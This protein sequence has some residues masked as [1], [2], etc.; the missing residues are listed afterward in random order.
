MLRYPTFLRRKREESTCP[1][2]SLLEG[3][4]RGWNDDSAGN[5]YGYMTFVMNFT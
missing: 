2:L 5:S 1:R 4:Y 3:L